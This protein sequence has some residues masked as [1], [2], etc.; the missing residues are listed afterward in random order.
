MD[1][2]EYYEGEGDDGWFPD[3]PYYDYYYAD[4]GGEEPYPGWGEDY[5]GPD[6]GMDYYYYDYP[7][8]ADGGVEGFDYGDPAKAYARSA[9]E[10][11][12]M[13]SGSLRGAS[14]NTAMAPLRATLKTVRRGLA[15]SDLAE[16]KPRMVVEKARSEGPLGTK[17]ATKRSAAGT[18]SMEKVRHDVKDSLPGLDPNDIKIRGPKADP[19]KS[20]VLVNSN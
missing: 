9:P 11:R 4:E 16:P 12:Q 20:S 10:R 13:E 3:E 5:W 1:Y 6:A 8:M 17:H 14:K 18:N 15:K 7:D 2:Y 19:M